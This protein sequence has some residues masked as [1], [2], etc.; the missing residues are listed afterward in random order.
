MILTLEI[1]DGKDAEEKRVDALSRLF[2]PR[3]FHSARES[4]YTCLPQDF[5]SYTRKGARI[6]AELTTVALWI[7]LFR[8]GLLTL[9]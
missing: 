6:S 2:N 9:G 4:L 7:P 8:E 1:L 3:R 5:P